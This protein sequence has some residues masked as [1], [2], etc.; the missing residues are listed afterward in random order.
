MLG[1]LR[2]RFDPNAPRRGNGLLALIISDYLAYYSPTPQRRRWQVATTNRAHSATDLAI[3]FLPRLLI[4]PS[5]HATALMRIALMGPRFLH[6]L[7]RTILIAKHSIDVQPNIEIGPGLVL[8][9]PIGVNLGWGLRIGTNVTLLHNVSI[10]QAVP[11]PPGDDKLSPTLEDDVVVFG[12]A[13]ILG[14]ITVGHGTV[15]GAGGYV[16]EDTPPES[17]CPG[18]AAVFRELRHAREARRRDSE[19][20]ADQDAAGA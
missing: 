12:D 6:G 13:W 5:L 17:V 19:R 18:R 2:S 11:R 10:G 9:H 4:N 16:D 20:A 7:W 8:P 15:V 1:R 14:P 3:L